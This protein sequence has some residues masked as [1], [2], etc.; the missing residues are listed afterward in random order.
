MSEARVYCGR[1]KTAKP[2]SEFYTAPYST[3][4]R[5]PCKS[6]LSEQRRSR[7]AEAGG[8]DQSYE[9]VLRRDYG[10]TLAQYNEQL[11]KQAGRCAICRR[12]ETVKLRS[13]KLRRLSVDH[14]HATGAIRGLLCHR[15]NILVW[16]LE[17]NHTTLAAI[18]DYIE[19]WRETFANGPPL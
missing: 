16:A 15:C 5:K 11:R 1:C 14:D 6:C 10:I 3:G 17:D 18:R 19:Q 4:P 7:Y 13:G 12:P 2:R 9:Q 8:S